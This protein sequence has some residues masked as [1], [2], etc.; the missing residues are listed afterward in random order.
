M[1][2]GLLWYA[3]EG[4]LLITISESR[5]SFPMT[6]LIHLSSRGSLASDPEIAIVVE[7]RGLT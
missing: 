1:G 2:E 6:L 7:W 5:S 3:T 4:G